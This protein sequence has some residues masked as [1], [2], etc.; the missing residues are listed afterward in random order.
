M[1]QKGH[2]FL[3]I[4]IV[5]ALFGSFI[6]MKPF[7]ISIFLA[8]MLV[9]MFDKTNKK[10]LKK[11]GGR[12]TLAS[13]LMCLW[14]MIILVIPFFI[15]TAM[16]VKEADNLIKEFQ[17]K[18]VAINLES[19][20]NLPIIQSFDF[21]KFFSFEGNFDQLAKS[22]QSVTNYLFSTIK[23]I[24]TGAT[25][26]IF[27]LVVCFFA[28]YYFFKDGNLIIKK[29]MDLSPLPSSQ[30]REIFEKFNVMTVATIKGTLVIALI[31]GLLMGIVFW[32]AGVQAPTIWGLVTALVSIIPLLGVFL[33]W[34][35]AG[36]I[37]LFM[38]NIWQAILIMLAGGIIISSIDNFL[39]PK[40]IEGETSLHPLLVFLATLGGIAVFGPLGFVIGPVIITLLITL[41]EIYQTGHIAK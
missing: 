24:Y 35:P 7:F 3:L 10:L 19:V 11:L 15:I 32:I 36:I 12:K 29:I 20:Q 16:T 5:I 1:Q 6:I 9:T 17:N 38:G 13:L 41:L 14:V 39:R 33:I 30:E 8:F 18:N 2:N 25:N 23:A 4:L 40:L 28:L 22:A 27:I 21:K 31:Q 34:L 37:L 26:F